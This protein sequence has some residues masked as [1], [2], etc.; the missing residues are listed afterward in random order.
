[1]NGFQFVF[2]FRKIIYFMLP[3]KSGIILDLFVTEFN[4]RRNGGLPFY[5]ELL[6]YL[7]VLFIVIFRIHREMIQ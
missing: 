5:K 6:Q 7:L 3:R 2:M 4:T 1:M